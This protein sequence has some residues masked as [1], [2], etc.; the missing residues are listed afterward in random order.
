MASLAI[1]PFSR[2][3]DEKTPTL[4]EMLPISTLFNVRRGNSVPYESTI[5]LNI[6]YADPSKASSNKSFLFKVATSL[7]RQQP[8]GKLRD[9][10]IFSAF[11]KYLGGSNALPNG[12]EKAIQ[13]IQEIRSRIVDIQRPQQP[14][15]NNEYKISNIIDV[16]VDIEIQAVVSPSTDPV[17]TLKLGNYVGS[18]R[19]RSNIR[20]SVH[21]LDETLKKSDGA[22]YSKLSS[23]LLGLATVASEANTAA[24]PVN[25]G[26]R[27][28]EML[29][30]LFIYLPSIFKVICDRNYERG[31]SGVRALERTGSTD[32]LEARAEALD[33]VRKKEFLRRYF[34]IYLINKCFKG[35]S[36]NKSNI[37]KSIFYGRAKSEA[38]K[39]KQD[40]CMIIPTSDC[41]V[42]NPQPGT[43]KEMCLVGCIC[44]KLESNVDLGTGS[45]STSMVEQARSVL[46][47]GNTTGNTVAQTS[48]ISSSVSS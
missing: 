24:G 27:K 14:E 12:N 33:F 20:L 28:K 1:L 26:D 7:F 43:N 9:Q 8:S 35:S 47:C 37:D 23:A 22:A 11:I 21:Q 3:P 13:R 6:S 38:N 2:N 5:Q 39:Y 19:E 4:I 18:T 36:L 45:A 42:T 40:I 15:T 30:N 10:D 31:F 34:D 25:I 46:N 44:L 32:P 48:T 29:G 17:I 41:F 16:W